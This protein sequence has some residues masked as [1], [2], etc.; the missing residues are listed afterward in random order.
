MVSNDLDSDF[1]TQVA[2]AITDQLHMSKASVF[3]KLATKACNKAIKVGR[4]SD[5]H[6]GNSKAETLQTILAPVCTNENDT[7]LLPWHVSFL[8]VCVSHCSSIN[9]ADV[10]GIWV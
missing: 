9:P 6:A 4:Q 2:E 8:R 3:S 7:R 5:I 1:E 10:S